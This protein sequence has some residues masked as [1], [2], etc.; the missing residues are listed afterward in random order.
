MVVLNSALWLTAISLSRCIPVTEAARLFSRRSDLDAIPPIN[1]STAGWTV[2]LQGS[3]T[4]NSNGAC[5]DTLTAPPA[6][7]HLEYLAIARGLYF[8]TCSG[9][10]PSETP[11]FES[12]STQLYNAAP[13][14]TQLK[15]EATFHALVPQLYDYNYAQLD[16]STLEC[17][18]TIGTDN[19]TAIVTLFEI[20]TFEAIA[21]ESILAPN[22]PDENGRWAHSTS[23]GKSW[24]IYR[25]EV[26][27]GGPPVC[28]SENTT[29]EKDYAAEY[30]F[31]HSEGE[32]LWTD[33]YMNDQGDATKTRVLI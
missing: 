32:D 9:A 24:D 31:F 23:P 20:A 12:Q 33:V 8:Y 1:V 10:G 6:D 22:D 13:L 28:G 26:V 17:F 4:C 3:Q 19:N 2:P 30:W 15:T 7:K 27:G 25:V 18:G 14:V 11:V 16:N 5:T 21:D 29:Y